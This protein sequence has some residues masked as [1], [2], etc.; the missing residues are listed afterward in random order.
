MGFYKTHQSGDWSSSVTWERYNGSAWIWP[1]PPPSASTSDGILIAPGHDVGIGGIAVSADQMEIRG[2]LR[3]LPGTQL[4]IVDGPGTDL[5]LDHPGAELLVRGKLRN[6]GTI[7]VKQGLLWTG[8]VEN[9]G[10]ISVNGTLRHDYGPFSGNP[11]RYGPTSALIL[12]AFGY[13]VDPDDFFWPATD[14]PANV[15]ILNDLTLNDDRTVSD[16]LDISANVELVGTLTNNGAARISGA[17]RLGGTFINNG[18]AR[19]SGAL[20]LTA[21]YANNG[22]TEVPG[23]VRFGT[24]TGAVTGNPFVYSGCCSRLEFNGPLEY[25]VA[26]NNLFWPGNAPP[27]VVAISGS[28]ANAAHLTLA[29]NRAAGQLNLSPQST[30][31]VS[32]NLTVNTGGTLRGMVWVDGTLV[33]NGTLDLGV[34]QVA[35]LVTNN[36]TL[37]VQQFFQLE[38]GGTATGQGFIYAE[39]SSLLLNNSMTPFVIDNGSAYWPADEGPPTVEVWGAGGIVLNEPR[40]ILHDF[41]TRGPVSNA[42]NL[43]IGREVQIFSGGSFDSSPIYLDNAK[44]IY[45]TEGPYAVGPEWA[46]GAFTGVGV[47]HHIEIQSGATVQLPDGNRRCPGDLSVSG[48]IELSPTLGIGLQVGGDLFSFGTFTTNFN[49]VILD[50]TTRQHIVGELILDFL[51]IDNPAGVAIAGQCGEGVITDRVTVNQQLIFNAGHIYLGACSGILSLERSAAGASLAQ[52][53]IT[54]E[55]GWVEGLVGP[56]E[57]LTF[58][59]GPAEMFYNPVTLAL[60]SA[61]QQRALYRARVDSGVKPASIDSLASVAATWAMDLSC[62]FGNLTFQWSAAQ[63]GPDFKRDTAAVY[64]ATEEL[65]SGMTTGADPYT[66]SAPF[67]QPCPPVVLTEFV[68]STSEVLTAVSELA[69]PRIALDQNTPNPFRG[70]TLIRYTIPTADVVQ[71]TVYDARGR[72]IAKLVDGRQ[73]PGSYELEWRPVDLAN[74]IYFYRLRVGKEMITK[75]LILQ[76]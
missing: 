21:T 64:T 4:T 43:T 32:G 59:I 57:S 14:G 56:G 65:P 27:A 15:R 46:S 22:T 48:T 8:E 68:V 7:E 61:D 18:A 35:G 52:H 67:G 37:H 31:R 2:I 51:M 39:G 38:E 53:V 19:I 16:T 13:T 41:R 71:L 28:G 40:T 25:V 55:G 72:E 11:V 54:Y 10:A 23:T 20:E 73:A 30:F 42:A 9:N 49:P 70:A 62:F 3:V 36:D 17:L 74:G 45:S 12:D 5:L 44:L 76:R 6:E 63:E 24:P 60:D 50:G 58:P 33:N 1:A 29:A 34:A 66:L 75:R 26:G 47:P 69:R